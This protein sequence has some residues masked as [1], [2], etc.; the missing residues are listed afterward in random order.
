M[1]D[2]PLWREFES[3]DGLLLRLLRFVIVLVGLL[4]L[5][6][7]GILELTLAPA[8]CSSGYSQCWSRSGWTA[9]PAPI[10]SH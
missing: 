7:T 8:A 2:S 10:S 9:A 5:C 4:F 1:T 6:S 3:G